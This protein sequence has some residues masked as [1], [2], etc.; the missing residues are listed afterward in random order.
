MVPRN[1]ASQRMT[2][3][4]LS[5]HR[6]P[7]SSWGKWP[8][9]LCRYCLVCSGDCSASPRC[10]CWRKWRLPISSTARNC[11]NLASPRPCPWQNWLLSALSSAPKLPNSCS[12]WRARSTA[13][14]PLTPVRRNMASNSAS[15]SAPAPRV[16]SFSRG[17]S[18]TGQSR[19]ATISSLEIKL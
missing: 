14:K 16:S 7:N 10:I 15:L 8:K 5:S 13:D 2:R 12:S 4:R 17:R 18:S 9:T 1:K 19:I 11:A 3:L 6:Q